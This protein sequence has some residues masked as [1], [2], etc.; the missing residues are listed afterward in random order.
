MDFTSG[1]ELPRGKTFLAF[2]RG[3]RKLVGFESG[4]EAVVRSDVRE[5]MQSSISFRDGF[6]D[7]ARGVS[8][9]GKVESTTSDRT[10]NG[11][12]CS[13]SSLNG[14]ADLAGVN[15]RCH[16]CNGSISGSTGTK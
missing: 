6:A 13:E 2:D 14:F 1:V 4:V 7:V 5:R 15:H 12:T 11:L 8:V 3:L 9:F 16:Q 10:I